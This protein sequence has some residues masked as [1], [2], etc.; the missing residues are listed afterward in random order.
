[1]GDLA[2]CVSGWNSSMPPLPK[3][4]HKARVNTT[5]HTSSSTLVSLLDFSLSH[6]RLQS[7]GYSTK[8]H[9]Q[10]GSTSASTQRSARTWQ[11]SSNMFS[12]D[13]S[14]CQPRIL[15]ITKMVWIPT[16]PLEYCGV[17]VDSESWRRWRAAM[18]SASPKP[19]VASPALPHS[20]SR[21]ALRIGAVADPLLGYCS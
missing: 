15:V 8:R 17:W 7:T 11:R 2:H 16:W 13:C 10:H 12:L 20:M 18:T 1:M 14:H 4:V 5:M 21:V 19:R 6:R 3:S 9:Q